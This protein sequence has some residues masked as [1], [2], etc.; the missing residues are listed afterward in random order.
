MN[1][2]LPVEH[3]LFSWLVEY[4][5]FIIN[6]R[7]VG[8]DGITAF[9]RVRRKNFAKRLIPF[10]EF[11]HIH[12]PRMSPER[13]RQG[14]LEPR[15]SEGLVLG[16]GRQSHSYL[17]Y[18]DGEFK[19]V[20]SV[21]RM[22][23]S[24]RWRAD[25]LQEVKFTVQDQHLKRG[26]KAVPFVDREAPKADEQGYRRAPRRLELRQGDFDPAMGGY[27]WTEH[28]PKCSRARMY[29]WKDSANLQHNEACR[30][31]IEGELAATDKGKA[32]LDLSK[33]RMDRRK[34]AAIAE[35]QE[36]VHGKEEEKAMVP[37]ENLPDLMV[38]E[39]DAAPLLQPSAEVAPEVRRGS[40]PPASARVAPPTD[41]VITDDEEEW[42]DVQD[43]EDAPMTP[44]GEEDP[45]AMYEPSDPASPRPEPMHIGHLQALTVDGSDADIKPA[46]DVVSTREDMAKDIIEDN[47]RIMEVLAQLGANPKKY[48]RERS[49]A[50]KALVSEIYSA[51]R[52]TRAAKLLPGLGLLP[53]FAFDL[54]TVNRAGVNWDFTR[55]EMRREA[56]D[57]VIH[58]KPMF[59]IGSPACTDYCSWQQLNA[60]RFGWPEGEQERRMVASDVHLAFVAELYKLQ[61]DA[62]RY[63]LHENP[64]GSKSWGRTPMVVLARDERVHKI[65]GDQCQYGQQSFRGDPVKKATGWMSNSTE[66]VNAAR[67]PPRPDQGPR[68]CDRQ[69]AMG[70]KLHKTTDLLISQVFYRQ[71]CV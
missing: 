46:V 33:Q 18:Q 35:D 17:V 36:L 61:M 55:E 68:S 58:G 19:H 23:L 43:G 39:P 48:R 27:G 34:G 63:F 37:P 50:V 56:R 31:R 14:V 16:Y 4:C 20:R 38:P 5:S 21:S 9:A 40:V 42:E 71:S 6:V 52:I 13:Q 67:I 15:T 32:R 64:E 70:S 29:G 7:V 12:V 11:V 51:P 54:T 69:P 49:R 41:V 28:C 60:Q 2:K 47:V 45:T 3:P 22:P 66:I 26:A 44:R 53:G 65:V 59:L 30:V 62:G 10:G 57:E 25:K 1:A 24:K 8:R